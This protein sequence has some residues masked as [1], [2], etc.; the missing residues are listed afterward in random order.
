MTPTSSTV[1]KKYHQFFSIAS[2]NVNILNTIEHYANRNLTKTDFEFKHGRYIPVPGKKFYINLKDSSE[3]RFQNGIYTELMEH[4]KNNR[5]NIAGFSYEVEPSY[6]PTKLTVKVKEKFK[7]RKDQ[8]EASAF[9]LAENENK[10]RLLGLRTGEGKTITSIITSVVRGYRTLL[11]IKPRY[12]KKWISDFSDVL[13]CDKSTVVTV[14]GS[15][16][17]RGLIY[18]G[19]EGTLKNDIVVVSNATLREYLSNFY[20]NREEFIEKDYGCDPDA[21]FRV[22]G[23]G[24][25]L[26]DE[27]HEDWHFNFMLYST[28]HVPLICGMSATLRTKD[29]FLTKTHEYAFPHIFRFTSKAVVNYNTAIASIYRFDK[30]EHIKTSYPGDTRY[31]HNRF[32]ESVLKHLGVR[33]RYFKYLEDTLKIGYFKGREPGDKALVLVSSV[34]LAT[35]FTEYLQGLY[36]DLNIKRYVGTKGD[37][38]KENLIDPDIRIATGMSAGTAVDIPDLTY[39]HMS[40]AIKSEDKNIQYLGRLRKQ[41]S[42]DTKFYYSVCLDIPFHIDAHEEKVILLQMYTKAIFRIVYPN[43]I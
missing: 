5:V 26:M 7:L 6:V 21:F 35:L 38:Y 9:V 24:T 34:E 28:C 37:P 14:T 12:F 25:L 41:E 23:V 3:Y 32:E 43:R 40:L 17:L 15:N 8:P 39:T 20:T 13:E 11:L 10:M 4:L 31:N 36:P 42:R 1:V 29:K 22:L 27:V 19:L 16:Q 30:P 33:K 2:S 18:S